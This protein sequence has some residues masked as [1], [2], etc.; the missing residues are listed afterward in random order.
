MYLTFNP[1]TMSLHVEKND[2]YMFEEMETMGMKNVTNTSVFVDQ[3]LFNVYHEANQDTSISRVGFQPSPKQFFRG[4]V[5][6]H[7]KEQPS[8]VLSFML[9]LKDVVDADL[10]ENYET[11]VSPEMIEYEVVE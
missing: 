8:H 5:V 4:S 2:G 7:T 6:I 3:T 10:D 1:D 11:I 9:V